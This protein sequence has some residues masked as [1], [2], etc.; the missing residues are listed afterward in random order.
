M[1]KDTPLLRNKLFWV[2]VLYFAEGFP[3]GIFYDF[4]PVYYRTQGVD[5]RQIGVLSLLG[6]AW[7]LKFLWAPAV[8]HWRHHRRWMAAADV[9]MGLVM[10]Y[11][12]RLAG[13]DPTVWIAIG[14]FT[15]LSATHDVAV[16]GYTIEF[17]DKRELGLANGI[18]IG[19]YRAGMMV[20]GFLLA[21]SDWL[22]WT[23]VFVLSAGLFFA[24]AATSLAAP[25]ERTVV[26]ERAK[27]GAEL[28]AIARS[29]LAL[30]AI[31]GLAAGVVWLID[32]KATWSA[33]VP[34]FWAWVALGC[35]ALALLLAASGRLRERGLPAAEARTAREDALARGPMF[36]AL[37]ELLRRPGMVP[38]LVF[39]L[40]F[41]LGDTA[42]GFMIKPFWVDAGFSATAI[43]LWSV[44]VGLGLTIAGGLVGGWI[45]DRIGIFHALWI[46][47]LAQAVSNLGY[48]IAAS[49]VPLA[50]AGASVPLQHQ[51]LV[52]AASAVESFT[53]GLGTAA[54]LAFLMAIVRKDHAATEYAL[55]SSVFALSRSVAGWVGG[56]GA[57]S[58]GYGNWFLLTF[59][60]AFP[61]Y[62][63]LPW[64]RRM[65]DREG[66]G[67]AAAEAGQRRD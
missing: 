29:P 20:A 38:V 52:Y 56:L 53:G 25:R 36:G 54:F 31:A 16:D 59:F 67:A 21:L 10:L 4:F 55:L 50:G 43:G 24:L 46:L 11:F 13:F 1:T 35:A 8:D 18:R 63:L 65:L 28:A 9:G 32:Q 33:R 41:K 15:A 22:G 44:N 62:L 51:V 48:W 57:Q 26:L 7:T 37:M 14:V 45:T 49:L 30:A 19:L 27:L 34:A 6:L 47:G 40:I 61:A 17:L 39:I 5:L 42:M 2:G 58:M 3:L 66:G 23:G 64:V 12:A 60:L